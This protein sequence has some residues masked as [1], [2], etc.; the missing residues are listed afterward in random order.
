M[1][2]SHFVIASL[3]FEWKKSLLLQI[4][5][6]KLL[7]VDSVHSPLGTEVLTSGV[8]PT[9]HQIFLNVEMFTWRN[10]LLTECDV[11]RLHSMGFRNFSNNI[12][13]SFDVEI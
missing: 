7:Q 1:P 4:H 10:V 5:S 2:S 13:K 11:L 12:K 9:T 8:Y 3:L 6:S